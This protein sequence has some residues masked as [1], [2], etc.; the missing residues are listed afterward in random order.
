MCF[1]FF[2]FFFSFAIKGI[3]YF[4]MVLG[5]L[6]WVVWPR[7]ELEAAAKKDLHGGLYSVYLDI[8]AGNPAADL[9]G[10]AL[11]VN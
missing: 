5:C 3:V 2:S 11:G 10:L 7:C 6:V 9:T 1:L 4:G 8:Y